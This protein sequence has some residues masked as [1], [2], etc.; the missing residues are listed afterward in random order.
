M[1]KVVFGY[2]YVTRLLPK[3]LSQVSLQQVFIT[4]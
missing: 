4:N 1:A 2:P 3:R